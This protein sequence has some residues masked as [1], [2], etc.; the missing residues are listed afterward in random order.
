M[1]SPSG[2]INSHLAN[3]FVEPC[4]NTS[5]SGTSLKAWL[6]FLSH[7]FSN[8]SKTLN[9]Q[10]WESGHF[11]SYQRSQAFKSRRARTYK[12]VQIIQSRWAQTPSRVKSEKPM[13]ILY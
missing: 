7:I 11:S 12:L 5:I 13:T 3:V 10:L 4:K 8:L 1:Y 9:T 2:S 6:R